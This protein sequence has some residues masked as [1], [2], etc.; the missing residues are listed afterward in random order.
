MKRPWEPPAARWVRT[1]CPGVLASAAPAMDEL[2]PETLEAARGGDRA[3]LDRFLAHYQPLVYRFGL[4]MCGN[5]DVAA[6]VLQETLIAAARTLPGFRGDSAVSTWLYTIARSFC[7]KQRR[8]RKDAPD[9]ARVVSLDEPGAE[10]ELIAGD[11]PAP[12]K[13]VSA[14][15]LRRALEQ[16]ISS[17][18]PMY[19]EVLLLRDVE[20]LSAPEVGAVMGLGVDAVKS[21]L[22]RAR[23]MVRE[24]LA[25]RDED[26]LP[27]AAGG[28]L[29]VAELVSR[30]REGEISADLCARMERHLDAC[31]RCRGR[32][33]AMRQV[34]SLCAATP[35]PVVPAELQAAVRRAIAAARGLA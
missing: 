3:A 11:G 2:S 28:C 31:P 12:D 22:H 8:R 29:D 13:E 15:E 27:V 20:G 33:D 17:L 6:D 24:Q 4:R 7:G 25:A 30:D 16:A 32:C 10:I 14:R 35:L 34:L 9:P 19:R 18:E 26:A 23:V 5:P 21:R 1:G